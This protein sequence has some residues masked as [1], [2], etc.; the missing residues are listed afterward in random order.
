MMVLFVANTKEKAEALCEEYSKD[1]QFPHSL[2]RFMYNDNIQTM[3]GARPGK[4]VVDVSEPLSTQLQEEV[5]Y[6]ESFI[7]AF[8]WG[9]MDEDELKTDGLYKSWHAPMEYI[10]SIR[11]NPHRAS[12]ESNE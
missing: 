8:N 1:D 10:E 11:K 4:L 9:Q 3:L 5:C 6:F 2:K 7:D 12:G